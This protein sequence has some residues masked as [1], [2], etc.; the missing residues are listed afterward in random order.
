MAKT[1]GNDANTQGS[2]N[3]T[4]AKSNAQRGVD[5]FNAALDASSDGYQAKV[6]RATTTTDFKSAFAPIVKYAPLMNEFLDY[7]INKLV[8][9]VVE[10]KMYSNKYSLLKREG[11]PLGT[12]YEYQYINPAEGRA[13]SIALGDTLLNRK[14]P[15]VKVQYFRRNREEQFWVTVPQPLLQGAFTTWE[16]L[17]DFVQGAIRTLYSGNEISEQNL[18]KFLLVESVNQSIIKT[19]DIDFDLATDANQ[20]GKNLIKASRKLALDFTFPSSAFNNYQE[21]AAAQ[22]IDDPTPAVTWVENEDVVIFITSEALVNTEVET[23]AGAFNLNETEFKQKIVP[24]DRF[25]YFDK[26]TQQTVTN[27]NIIAIVADRKAFEYR[28][29]FMQASDFFNSAGL[30]RNHYLTVFQTYAVNTCANA[31]AIMKKQ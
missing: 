11:F 9:Q 16:Q 5:V 13:Y 26:S 21:Y 17:D 8:F 6:G 25:S 1:T 19:M 4:S 28:D 29:N 7:V 22:G 10:A 12:D 23:L 24:V 20:A 27:D 31:I 18:V 30:Y 2:V 15:D 14:K 3:D